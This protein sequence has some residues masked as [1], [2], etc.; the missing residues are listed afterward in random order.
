MLFGIT[1]ISNSTKQAYHRES[2]AFFPTLFRLEIKRTNIKLKQGRTSTEVCP[3]PSHKEMKITTQS[4]LGH[5][6]V[7]Y[8][9][10]Y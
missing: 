9:I 8:I 3:E 6:K 2:L 4:R 1:Q 10:G 5:M 7:S